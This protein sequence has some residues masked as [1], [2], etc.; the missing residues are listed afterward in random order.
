MKKI[1]ATIPDA[2]EEQ[3]KIIAAKEGRSISSV[4]AYA[5][6]SFLREYKPVQVSSLQDKANEH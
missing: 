5:I 3:L 1:I 2:F 6:E 4:V